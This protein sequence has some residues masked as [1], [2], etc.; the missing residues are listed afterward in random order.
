MFN[1]RVTALVSAHMHVHNCRC[2]VSQVSTHEHLNTICY[3]AHMG[4][5]LGYTISYICMEAATL[6][7]WNLVHGHSPGSGCLPVILWYMYMYFYIVHVHQ[8][9][10]ACDSQLM[11]VSVSFA[12]TKTSSH[13][14]LCTLKHVFAV[15]TVTELQSSV[16]CI[17]TFDVCGCGCIGVCNACMHVF[18]VCVMDMPPLPHMHVSLPPIFSLSS[19]TNIFVVLI[20]SKFPPSLAKSG[21]LNLWKQCCYMYSHAAQ[22]TQAFMSLS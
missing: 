7:P 12:T 4:T 22:Y 19:C 1:K 5:N 10:T 17:C 6:T 16:H 14:L 13:C 11:N 20:S 9:V 18:V 21:C 15:I 2:G 8:C 3:L